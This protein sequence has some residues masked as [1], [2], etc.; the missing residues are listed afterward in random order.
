MVEGRADPL[1][2]EVSVIFERK[3]PVDA[4]SKPFP[5]V[6]IKHGPEGEEKAKVE[7]KKN[8]KN[9]VGVETK[10][11]VNMK[12]ENKTGG[13]VNTSDDMKVESGEAESAVQMEVEKKVEANTEDTV[14]KTTK[15][16][17]TDDKTVP[18]KSESEL[19]LIDAKNSTSVGIKPEIDSIKR[20]AS[21]VLKA[22]SHS[23]MDSGNSEAN[24]AS[25][26]DVE[27]ANIL[28]V[29]QELKEV[30]VSTNSKKMSV[31]VKLE[32]KCEGKSKAK[33]KLGVKKSEEKS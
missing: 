13:K 29:K 22:E 11:S 24:E 28:E 12:V 17:M 3:H 32:V 6:R 5:D 15:K 16:E 14:S 18:T 27:D 31:S 2:K 30:D 7:V 33:V 8:V 21:A 1:C 10:D 19:K 25:K 4:G 23:R 26:V 9:I 20:K